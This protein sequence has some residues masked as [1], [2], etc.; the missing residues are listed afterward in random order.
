MRKFLC[1]MTISSI[2]AVEGREAVIMCL[3]PGIRRNYDTVASHS[4]FGQVSGLPLVRAV[5]H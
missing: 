3:E 1:M 4:I 5:E 2:I